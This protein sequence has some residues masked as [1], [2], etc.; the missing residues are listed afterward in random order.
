MS[1]PQFVLVAGPNG[2]GKSTLSQ[3]IKHRFPN[4]EVI[5]PDAIAKSLTGSFATVDKEKVSAGKQTVSLIHQKLNARESLLVESTI[6]GQTYLRFAKLAKE[7]GY[8]TVF[9]Y[10]ALDSANMSADRV[11]KRVKLGG[12]PIDAKDIER[13][14][15]RSMANLKSFIRLF[16]SSHIYDNSDHYRWVAGFREGVLHNKSKNVPDWLKKYIL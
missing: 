4:V 2:G 5:D 9:I 12:H 11:K 6:S 13:R 8:R 7:L 1:R 10:V 14:Y 3:S 15:P 16:E